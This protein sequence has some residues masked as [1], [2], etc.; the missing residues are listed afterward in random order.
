MATTVKTAHG[1]AIT[2][3]PQLVPVLGGLPQERV[4]LIVR[5]GPMVISD[6]LSKADAYM[7]GMGLIAAA[8]DLAP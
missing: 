6:A 5:Q 2:A 4:Q 3:S 7:L 8:G 1:R